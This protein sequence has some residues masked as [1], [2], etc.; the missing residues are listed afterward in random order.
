MKHSS[1]IP[2]TALRKGAERSWVFVWSDSSIVRRFL[3]APEKISAWNWLNIAEVSAILWSYC[4]SPRHLQVGNAHYYHGCLQA[5]SFT[6]ANACTRFV[7]TRNIAST[8]PQ[9]SDTATARPRATTTPRTRSTMTERTAFVTTGTAATE[10]DPC[11]PLHSWLHLSSRWLH[12]SCLGFCHE[13]RVYSI[14]NISV[15]TMYILHSMW[16]W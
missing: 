9:C 12:C 8:C 5:R 4:S 13:P 14:A 7:S 2:A 3:T 15:N 11:S 16:V 6:H 1:V 10:R